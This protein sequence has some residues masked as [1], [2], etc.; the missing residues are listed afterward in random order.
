[1]SDPKEIAQLKRWDAAY[2]A[3]KPEV[4][5]HVYDLHRSTTMIAYPKDE[6]WLTVGSPLAPGVKRGLPIP[7]GSLDKVRP[8]D[9]VNWVEKLPADEDWLLLPKFDGLGG[10]LHYRSNRLDVAY[11]RGD[12]D[13]G[14]VVTQAARYVE[15]VL[16]ELRDPLSKGVELFA[17]GEFVIHRKLF[18]AMRT[19]TED[20][21]AIIRT[22]S[23]GVH[24]PAIVP[25]DRGYV[26]P[27]N[28]CAGMMTIKDPSKDEIA[29]LNLMTFVTY[30]VLYRNA[31]GEWFQS[32][33][34]CG[35]F[36]ELLRQG[37]ITAQNPSRYTAGS[38]T[39]TERVRKKGEKWL[40]QYVPITDPHLTLQG[41]WL[42]DK[43]S[44]VAILDPEF[45]KK[46]L[47]EWSEQTDID[48]DGLVLEATKRS[49]AEKIGLASDG[50][51]P[52]YAVA[53]KLDQKDQPT[54]VGTVRDVEWNIS[55]RRLFK[56]LIY[57]KAPMYFN[58][59]EVN[60]LTGHNYA[61]IVE[62]GIGPGAVIEAIRSGDV[63]PYVTGVQRKAE[64]NAPKKCPHCKHELERTKRDIYCPNTEC[65]GRNQLVMERFFSA[66]KID[67]MAG[68][69]ITLLMKAGF[70]LPHRVLRAT[71]KELVKVVG[72]AKARQIVENRVKATQGVSLRTVMY[73]SGCFMNEITGLG[74]SKLESIIDA[75]GEKEI[76]SG[77]LKPGPFDAE[78]I[79]EGGA[80]LFWE[81]L[82][83][84]L[85]LWEQ[86]KPYITLR[87]SIEGGKLSGQSFCWTGFR[88]KE[89]EKLV[90]E[91]GGRVSGS[92]SRTLTALFCASAG[93]TKDKKAQ[94]YGVKVVYGGEK[95]ADTYLRGLLK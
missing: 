82:P 92:V 20:K 91:H 15:G 46:K 26:N 93:S 13:I 83:E 81:N 95:M 74:K 12:G 11:S 2:A 51:T 88:S 34:R 35:Q 75:L 39:L 23:R 90:E 5:D 7:M 40:K 73:A 58:G 67:G 87:K 84:F 43:D 49:T 56:P 47:A 77:K 8:G 29:K 25:T 31:K 76:L 41:Q 80:E 53:I 65:V 14:R 32:R 36:N 85:T 62:M 89:L 9:I 4:P 37:F 18:A 63:I 38:A 21:T 16:P 60:K 59:V 52:K 70:D 72:E 86:W 19:A 61:K 66:I 54:Q 22:N 50:K 44:K 55:V 57:L 94:S 3:G 64:I 10:M 71:E 1:M 27:R 78:K 45:I 28:F 6:Y 68:G 48:L 30:K 24:T 17:I 42:C 33:H 69:V 79:G